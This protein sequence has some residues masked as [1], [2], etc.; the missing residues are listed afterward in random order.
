MATRL[1]SLRERHAG[2][3]AQRDQVQARLVAHDASAEHQARVELFR[4]NLTVTPSK[5]VRGQVQTLL[6]VSRHGRGRAPR[7]RRGHRRGLGADRRGGGAST[8][9]SRRTAL[10]AA[11]RKAQEDG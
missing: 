7:S 3:V 4:A 5:Q 11:F 6:T 1:D 8:T 2:L 10:E 9:P